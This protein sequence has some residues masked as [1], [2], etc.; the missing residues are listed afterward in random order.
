M[1][2]VKGLIREYVRSIVEIR[3]SR[4]TPEERK[5]YGNKFDINVFSKLSSEQEMLD[6]ARHF[7]KPL[8]KGSSRQAFLFSSRYALKIA[9]NEKGLAQNEAE[10]DAS[11]NSG[12]KS[13]V[14][15]VQRSDDKH[16]WL[17]SDLVR[18]LKNVQEFEQLTGSGFVDFVFYI[19]D[20]DET[21]Q[22]DD[23]PSDFA[24]MIA[25]LMQKS[26]LV[27]ADLL[28]FEHWGV[29]GDGRPVLIDYGYNQDVWRKHYKKEQ[30][31]EQ[32]A[33]RSSRATRDVNAGIPTKKELSPSRAA[34]KAAATV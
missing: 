5:Q 27:A 34:A 9:L 31:E 24:L 32:N 30:E 2:N 13:I 4:S 7:L 6:Y 18:E 29:T 22:L 11:T 14:A 1:L 26:D 20:V 23:P 21:G 8:G 3:S 33:A 25:K 10:L 28:K 12:M 15:R 17:L 16:R 19:E